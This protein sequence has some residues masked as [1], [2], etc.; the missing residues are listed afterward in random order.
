MLTAIGSKL[1]KIDI[2]GLVGKPSFVDRLRKHRF[3][4]AA[5]GVATGVTRVWRSNWKTGLLAC[6]GRQPSRLS[7]DLQRQAG[8]PSAMTCG[9]PVF[10]DGAA[11]S[12]YL[13]PGPSLSWRC[14]GASCAARGTP[15]NG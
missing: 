6:Q 15:R 2:E 12:K 10:R 5:Y 13:R 11:T 7:K 9:T 3:L 4:A 8:S 1:T 14:D